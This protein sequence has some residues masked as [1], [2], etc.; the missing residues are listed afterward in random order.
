MQPIMVEMD[1][2]LRRTYDPNPFDFLRP[3]CLEALADENQFL[4]TDSSLRIYFAGHWLQI[5]GDN[6]HVVLFD[7]AT[8]NRRFTLSTRK[9]TR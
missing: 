1:T 3:P 4:M 9:T 7:A 5:G 2:I 8:G 6:R